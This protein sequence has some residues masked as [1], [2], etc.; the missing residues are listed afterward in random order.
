MFED[1][2]TAHLQ[3]NG[4]GYGPTSE[5]GTSKKM[6]FPYL[7]ITH[8]T[9]SNIVVSNKT[10]IPEVRLTF[11]IVDQLNNQVNLADANG[12]NSTNEQEVLSDCF[13]IAQDLVNYI[14]TQMGQFGVMLM[15]ESISIE[16][17][18]DE[19]PDAASG[20]V[21]DVAL[22]LKHSNCI[23]PLGE[24]T[25]TVPGTSNISLRYLTC[26]TLNNCASF[27]EAIDNLQEQID[28]IIANE[29]CDVLEDCEIIQDIQ[30]DIL[31]LSGDTINIQQDITDIQQDILT[32]SGDTI[33]LQEQIDNIISGSTTYQVGEYVPDEGGIIISAT[34]NG[35]TEE[36][37]VVDLNEATIGT[38][39]S[40]NISP[41]GLTLSFTDGQTNTQTIINQ[42]GH[43][44]SAAKI[45][46]DLVSAGKNDWYLPSV[47][48][49]KLC[50]DI[51]VIKTFE[52]LALPFP[53]TISFGN[54]EFYWSSTN[55]SSSSGM[56]YYV[57]F[58]D[59]APLIYTNTSTC[60]VRAIRK[61]TI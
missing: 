30:T 34:R 36:Y 55:R 26:D 24:I 27:N 2:A 49:L 44:D 41:V 33:N 3:L 4:F 40:T 10:Q 12:S 1:F 8:R 35:L 43:T 57:G 20:W 25:F 45:C 9:P 18:Y 56:Y 21:M 61:F 60:Y 53:R 50:F 15:D 6:D 58:D 59:M 51:A 32:L 7:W 39:A 38:V 48:E 54:P 14:S 22:K 13:Q 42:I 17:V 23:T 31:S 46:D 52:Q 47:L 5:I 29:I 37:L 11:I 16:P 28:N 19:T